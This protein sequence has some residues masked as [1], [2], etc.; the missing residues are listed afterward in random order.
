MVFYA[1]VKQST[2]YDSWRYVVAF[3]SREVADEWWRAVS[4]SSVASFT[5]SIKRVNAQFYLHD[6]NQ[7][8]VANSLV[9]TGVAT[10]FL[11]KVIFLLMDDLGGRQLSIIPSPSHFVDHVSEN[12]FYIRSKVSP[13]VYWYFP[14]D[15]IPTAVY[16]S[17]TERTRF[18]IAR[19]T[20]EGGHK[21]TIMIGSDHVHITLTLASLSLDV[22]AKGQVILSSAPRE[23]LFG[24]LLG[25]FT[26][27]PTVQDSKGQSL[28]MRELFYNENGE[29]WE[30]A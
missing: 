28:N 14:P 17:H 22:D 19:H 6:V 5:N 3:A 4:T 12:S 10:Q 9:T 13:Y 1:Y 16:V 11:N 21:G 7:A 18:R 2:N 15:V 8:N 26:V 20:S 25:K 24:D 27:G 23:F 29:D 30:L